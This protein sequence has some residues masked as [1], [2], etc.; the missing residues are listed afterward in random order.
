MRDNAFEN[1]SGTTP[2]VLSGKDLFLIWKR[3]TH[4]LVSSGRVAELHQELDTAS[5]TGREDAGP[6]GQ[7]IVGSCRDPPLILNESVVITNG[8]TPPVAWNALEGLI[9]QYL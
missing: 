9:S 5:K 7:L 6:C 4:S 2:E 8:R 1:P 3:I